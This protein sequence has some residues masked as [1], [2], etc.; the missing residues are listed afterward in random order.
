ME[1][2]SE[3]FFVSEGSDKNLD[4]YSEPGFMEKVKLMKSRKAI[5]SPRETYLRRKLNS[6]TELCVPDK[7]GRILIPPRL[8]EYAGIEGEALVTG[9]GENMEIWR[10]D[11]YERYM[12]DQEAIEVQARSRESQSEG[13]SSQTGSSE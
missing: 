7:Q 6:T 4:L 2:G 3:K 13:L 11:I 12:I 10:E 5:E 8:R 9:A 1:Q